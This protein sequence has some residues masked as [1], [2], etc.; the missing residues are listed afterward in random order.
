[1]YSTKTSAQKSDSAKTSLI[2]SQNSSHLWFFKFHLAKLESFIRWRKDRLKMWR[3]ARRTCEKEEREGRSH[4]RRKKSAGSQ[5]AMKPGTDASRRFH[6]T[7]GPPMV[8]LPISFASSADTHPSIDP[9]ALMNSCSEELRARTKSGSTIDDRWRQM[10]TKDMI[11]N[12][13]LA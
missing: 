7:T 3:C 12:N 11:T 10:R 2:S 13:L 6:I 9:D 8:V 4:C 1:M 5:I